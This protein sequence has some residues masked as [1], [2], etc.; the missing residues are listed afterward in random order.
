MRVIVVAVADGS[1]EWEADAGEQV[2]RSVAEIVTAS[3]SA[4]SI[5]GDGNVPAEGNG[6][7]LARLTPREIEVLRLMSRGL[8]NADIARRLFISEKTAKAHVSHIFEKLEVGT[9]VQ[10]VIA[11][12][13]AL[14]ADEMP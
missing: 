12:K 9:R 13:G 8:A 2:A 14:A 3:T 1:G 5:R 4:M 6:H 11:A 10:A 7:R